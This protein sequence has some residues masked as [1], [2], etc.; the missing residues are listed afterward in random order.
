MSFDNLAVKWTPEEEVILEKHL[1]CEDLDDLMELLPGR[2]KNSIKA[3]IRRVK[4]DLLPDALAFHAMKYNM[5]GDSLPEILTRMKEAGYTFTLKNLAKSIK[6]QETKLRTVFK[7]K[8]GRNP[9]KEE[10]IEFANG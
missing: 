3:K 8:H 7:A 5:S 4:K 10:L 6:V 9:S 2:S 1:D